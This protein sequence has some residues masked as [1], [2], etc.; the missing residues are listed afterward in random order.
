V[1]SRLSRVAKLIALGTLAIP[2]RAL[3]QCP[4]GTPPP[5]GPR[6][7]TPAPDPNRIAFLPF[8]VSTADTLLG[9]GLAE[10]LATEF[11]G[12]SG[13]RAVHMGTVLRTWRRAGGSLRRPLDQAQTL[14]VAREMDAGLVVEGSVVGLGG[15]LSLSASVIPVS[16]GAAR[17][18]GSV[19]GPADSLESLVGR[20]TAAILAASGAERGGGPP[21]ALT[22]SPGAMRAYLEGLALFRRGRFA[23]AG[24]AFERAFSLDSSFGRAAFMRYVS[25]TWED[26]PAQDQWARTAWSLRGRLSAADRVLLDAF[27]GSGYPAP[28]TP[29]SELA[30]RRRAVSVMPESPEAHYVLAD[31]LLHNGAANDIA[32][33]LEQARAGFERSLALDTQVTVLQHLLDIGLHTADTVLLRR[34]WPAYGRLMQDPNWA[35]PYGMLVAECTADTALAAAIATRPVPPD[36]WVW[37]MIAPALPASTV[38]RFYRHLAPALAAEPRMQLD[39]LYHR[40]LVW[41]GRPSALHSTRGGLPPGLAAAR[42]DR[43]IVLAWLFG[44]GDSVAAAGAADRLQTTSLPSLREQADALCALAL[45]QLR[46]GQRPAYDREVLLRYRGR[47]CAVAI[48][49]LTAWRAGAPDLEAQ[50]A[51][52]DSLFRWSVAEEPLDTKG[53]LHLVLARLWEARGDRTRALSAVRLRPYGFGPLVDE[54]AAARE[55]GRLAALVGDTT[56]A[57]RAYRRYLGFRRDAERRLIPQRDSVRA[58]LARLEGRR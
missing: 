23:N 32:D 41:T 53:F 43:L 12:E 56:G 38:D 21:G 39:E 15:R 34:T 58:E 6:R 45:W 10:L 31:Y 16:G 42:L 3:A 40:A 28:R 11:T 30:D 13:P 48:D 14:R 2:A 5:C 17:R 25:A 26:L 44:D 1:R 29:Q 18:T 47:L 36:A 8:R 35:V 24:G 22:G 50:L 7:A 57:I 52:A 19:S 27:L 54:A 55:E 33:A 9:E 20:L 46:V 49:L 51:V 37:P 4:D